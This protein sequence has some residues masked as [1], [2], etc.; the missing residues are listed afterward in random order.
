MESSKFVLSAYNIFK[1]LNDNVVGINLISQIF[2]SLEKEKYRLLIDNKDNIENIK[3]YNEPLFNIMKKLGVIVP[4]NEDKEFYEKALFS[5][6]LKLF[7]DP[8]FRLTINPTLNCN[9]SCWYCY[10]QH[11]KKYMSDEVKGRI[12]KLISRIT[13]E[14]H[15]QHF[16]L[17]WFG[18]EP[19]LCYS[20]HIVPITRFAKEECDKHGISF[21]S[22]M[23]TNGYLLSSNMLSFFQKV[24]MNSFQI[25]LDGPQLIHNSIRYTTNKTGSYEKIVKNIHLLAKEL[26]PENLCLRIN[27]TLDNLSQ[28]E[29]IIHSFDKEVRPKIKVLFQQVWQDELKEKIKIEEIYKLKEQFKKNE[30]KVEDSFLNKNGEFACY[31]DNLNQAVINYDGR[32][33]KCTAL[34]FEKEKEDGCLTESGNI[35]WN[36]ALAHKLLYATFENKYCKDCIFLPVCYGPCHKKVTY[37]RDGEDFNKY[38]FKFG[39]KENL[40]F[41]FNKFSNLKQPIM[42]LEELEKV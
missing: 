1:E 39:I 12:L 8:F 13:T 18:G 26:S 6:R 7:R 42:T 11:T 20:N 16:H 5:R 28:I 33:F 37:Y 35:L 24:N 32:I 30:F 27:Y 23:T 34:N 9:F 2:F 19:L 15:I 22:G 14:Q 31:A 41:L 38:C 17:D 3:N 25:T 21:T 40:D 29:N 10:E 36:S 4:V